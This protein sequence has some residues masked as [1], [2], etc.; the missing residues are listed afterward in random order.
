MHCMEY[1]VVS[2]SVKKGLQGLKRRRVKSWL[3]Y[4]DWRNA[5]IE[6]RHVSYWPSFSAQLEHISF[7]VAILPL[8]FEESLCPLCPSSLNSCHICHSYHALQNQCLF[9]GVPEATLHC[10]NFV[11]RST[12]L[13]KDSIWQIESF[14]PSALPYFYEYDCPTAKQFCYSESRFGHVHN[15][16]HM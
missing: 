3:Q 13:L 1:F 14:G 9:I 15:R 11:S 4:Q 10:T 16:I 12:Y 8:L 5:Q 7:D 2:W 6:S